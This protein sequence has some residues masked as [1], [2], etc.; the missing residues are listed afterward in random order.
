MSCFLPDSL[1]SAILDEISAVHA[2][3]T[4]L[5]PRL[6]PVHGL[7]GQL[8]YAGQ[9][10][11]E[12]AHLIRAANIAGAA[13]LAVSDS[14]SVLR[15]ATRNGVADFAVT[16]LDEALRIL[17]NEIR[18]RLPVAVAIQGSPLDIAQQM[19]LRGVQ[20]DLLAPSIDAI[21]PLCARA[22]FL[23][24]GSQ[25]VN[26]QPDDPQPGPAHLRIWQL[27]PAWNTRMAE[28]DAQL[29]KLLPTDDHASR[30]WLHLA[31]RYLP[32]AA[33]RLRSAGCSELVDAQV[34]SLLASEL[35]A[36]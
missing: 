36:G 7:G 15:K 28:L 5:A 24:R 30:R 16:S 20:P 32:R 3:Y 1:D 2:F 26:P 25:L 13:S 22:A 14:P 27:P 18:K 29:L 31:P 9:L 12:A 35:S 34:R 23:E 6:D 11:A 21:Q 8:L 19:M 17:K 33:R 10:S 4:A